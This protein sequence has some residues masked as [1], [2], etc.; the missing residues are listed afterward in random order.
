MLYV[1][2]NDL[3]KTK[4]CVSVRLFSSQHN[5]GGTVQITFFW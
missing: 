3:N 2:Q 5:I 4:I 1:N